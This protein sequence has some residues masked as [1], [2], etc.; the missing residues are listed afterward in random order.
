MV[1]KYFKKDRFEGA[2]WSNGPE[3]SL[4]K[5]AKGLQADKFDLYRFC[6]CPVKDLIIRIFGT[7]IAIIGRQTKPAG[8]D[9]GRE[10]EREKKWRSNT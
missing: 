3:I 4:C 6:L 1:S 7:E 8:N 9:R 2:L 5:T 10:T